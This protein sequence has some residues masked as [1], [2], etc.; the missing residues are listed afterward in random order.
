MPYTLPVFNRRYDFW[1]AA[2]NPLVDPPDAAAVPCQPYINSRSPLHVHLNPNPSDL[3]SIILR[4][5]LGVYTPHGRDVA[6]DVAV[7]GVFW[8]VT[9]VYNIH[10]GFPNEYL[11]AL[12][13]RCDHS[14]N[15]EAPAL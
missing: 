8:R 12:V 14:G 1:T 15:L 6:A 9:W 11:V 13:N 10:I 7:P 3:W 2:H 5:P 4:L